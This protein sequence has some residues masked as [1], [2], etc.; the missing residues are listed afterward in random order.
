[1]YGAIS[2]ADLRIQSRSGWRW[3]VAAP[4]SHRLG[5]LTFRLPS[6]P[7]EV[8]AHPGPDAYARTPGGSMAAVYEGPDIG[9]NMATPCIDEWGDIAATRVVAKGWEVAYGR[10]T[11]G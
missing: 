10:R 1:M 8:Y 11:Q 7:R 4:G 2:Y 5:E 6:H 3:A 9:G